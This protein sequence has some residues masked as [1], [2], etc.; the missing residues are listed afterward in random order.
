MI[1]TNELRFV[2]REVNQQISKVPDKWERKTLR[3]LQCRTVVRFEENI[4]TATP[5]RDVPLVK[6]EA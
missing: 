3:V 4:V 2:E 1:A 6:E 5:W